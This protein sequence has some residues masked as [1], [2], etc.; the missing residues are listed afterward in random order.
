MKVAVLS[1]VPTCG[2]S[3]LIQ[4]LGGV[5]SRSQGRK[6]VVF[7][8]GDAQDNVSMITC[9]NKNSMLDNPHIV[10]AMVDNAGDDA[11]NL[12]NYGAQAGDE[13]IYYFDILNAAMSSN[14][15]EDFLLAAIDKVPADL[16]LIE[17]AGDVNSDLN[18]KV[19]AKCDCSLILTESSIKGCKK[20]VSLIEL[21]PAGKVKI[22]K[23]IVLA[24]YDANV[25]SDKRFAEKIGMKSQNIFK[26]PYNSVAAKLAFSGELDKIVYN[27]LIGDYEVV[28][29]RRAC[30]DIMEYL[31]DSDN[32]KVIRG[33]ERWYK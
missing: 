15:K 5:Y 31:F 3:V 10:K 28:T 1:A 12:L 11:D 21:L 18:K 14:E 33:I 9:L 13:H 25:C 30:Q 7:T 2:K 24:K 20:L 22:N 4:I 29:F 16:T 19:L 6:T 17:V 27:I 26:F 23:A 8:T 32:R